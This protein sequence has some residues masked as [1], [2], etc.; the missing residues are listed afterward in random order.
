MRTPVHIISSLLRQARFVFILISLVVPSLKTAAQSFAPTNVYAGWNGS[1]AFATIPIAPGLTF[2]QVSR[3]AGIGSA[4][5]VTSGITSNGWDGPASLTAAEAANKYFTFS[6]TSNAT[7]AFNVTSILF[8]LQRSNTGPQNFQLECSVNGGP[9]VLFG[10]PFSNTSS[11]AFV[12]TVTA[13]SAIF[14][15]GGGNVVFRLYAWNASGATGTFRI[16]NN[17]AINGAVYSLNTTGITGSPFCVSASSG[18][19][20]NVNYSSTGAYDAGNVFT[21]QLSDATGSFAS[22]VNIGT[23]TGNA[24]TGTINAIIPAGTAPGS[25]YRIRVISNSPAIDGAN[26]GSDI[27]IGGIDFSTVITSLTCNASGDGAASTTINSGA[28]PFTYAWST[29]ATTPSI[30]GLAAGNYSVTVTDNAGCA[31]SASVTVTEPPAI[32]INTVSSDVSCNG[33]TNGGITLSV[34]GGSSPYSYSWSNS[35]TTQNLSG[36]SAGN[37]SVTVTD[38]TGCEQN[39]SVTIT[40]P[41]VITVSPSSTNVNCNG[42]NNGT[43]NL[44]VSGGTSPYTFAWSNSATTQNISGLAAGTYSVT[45]S[46][47]NGCSQSASVT[48]TEPAGM[49]VSTSSTNVNCN[50]GNNGT[51]NLSVNGGTSPYAFAWSNSAATQNISGLTAGTYSVTITDNNG[52]SQNES[53]TIT[54]PSGMTISTSST[55]V[56]CN[57]GNNGTANLSVSGGTSPYTFAWS[58]SAATQ[59]ISGL[60]AGTYSVT[61]TDNQGCA[62]NT[63]VTITQPTS[64]AVSS[65]S[66][67]VNCNGGNNGTANLTVS[68]GTSP[69]SYVWSNSATTQNI[70]NLTAGTYSVIVTDNNGCAQN[71]S[72]TITQPTAIA[73]S[74]SSTNVNCNGGNNG[75]ANLSVSGGASP[76]TFAWSNSATTP[77]LSNLTAGTYSVIV[78]DNNGCAQNASVIITQ[79]FAINIT[80]TST[81]AGCNGGNTGAANLVVNGGTSPYSYSWSNSAT[82]QNISG[83]AAGTYSVIVTD[84]NGC[85]QNTSVTIT[86]PTPIT[87]SSVV[88]DASCGICPDGNID[89]TVNGGTS[90]YNFSWSNS[91]VTED[92]SGLV[93]AMYYVTITDNNGCQHVDSAFVD[94]S[95]GI[96]SV[97]S[98]N[99]INVYPN[100]STGENIHFVLTPAGAISLRIFDMEGKEIY[101]TA[102]NNANGDFEISIPLPVGAYTYKI[103]DQQNFIHAG[104]LII[105]K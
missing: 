47:N 39:A 86:E 93:T 41:A 85:A 13:A 98:T 70:S 66:T 42:G 19:S 2:S 65:S 37:Y 58:N 97:N 64:I 57:G 74:A 12:S 1:T 8:A 89:L 91:A 29:S 15:P 55:T 22:P 68:G 62:Q 96:A 84:N 56:N 17:T 40:E 38:N 61:I 95:T 45:I 9:F 44:A 33:G 92:I 63:S 4:T 79:P 34:N 78:T 32:T 46:D 7:N 48:I 20:V 54:Q 105:M 14:I 51:A 102:L 101:T 49:N 26:N 59:N 52:C 3:G 81:N 25:A 90:P 69:Y 71:A 36:L 16:N 87:S 18:A 104:Q 28:S 43:A 80:A 10:N 76:Y 23:L 88:T 53:V 11:S 21:A 103:Q 50:G 100:P 77:V 67:S 6:I 27:V 83:L 82:T 94:F 31:M 75:T 35:T 99:G 30:T 5:P 73:I 72:V 24:P 60:T